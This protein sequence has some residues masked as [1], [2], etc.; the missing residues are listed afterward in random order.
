MAVDTNT[1][2]VDE[3]GGRLSVSSTSKEEAGIVEEHYDHAIERA[4]GMYQPHI[5]LLTAKE[6]T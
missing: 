4:Y 1:T 6:Q 3:K 2:V 5:S